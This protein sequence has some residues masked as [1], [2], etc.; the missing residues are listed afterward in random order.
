MSARIPP[1]PATGNRDDVQQILDLAASRAGGAE[2]VMLTMANHPKLFHRFAGFF[3]LLLSGGSLPER[4][5]ELVILRVATLCDSQYEWAQHRRMA[6]SAGVGDDEI[7]RVLGGPAMPEWSPHER[8]LLEATDELVT[9]HRLAQSTW[10]LLAE[11]LDEKQ[12]IEFV[13][14][15]GAYVMVAGF[16]NAVEVEFEPGVEGFPAGP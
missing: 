16:L 7:L 12:L 2:N 15:V 10:D 5:R 4:N 1:R 13:I 9:T 11:W 14:L 6:R 3:G 8:V